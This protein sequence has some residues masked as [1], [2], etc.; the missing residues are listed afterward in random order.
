[1]LGNKTVSTD[2]ANTIGSFATKVFVEVIVEFEAAN[3][4]DVATWAIGLIGVVI[5]VAFGVIRSVP[6]LNAGFTVGTTS[7]VVPSVLKMFPPPSPG[8]P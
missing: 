3:V 1:M 8:T 7:S 6:F 5:T 2:D 4:T